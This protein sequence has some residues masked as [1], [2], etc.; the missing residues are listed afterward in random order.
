MKTHDQKTGYGKS[1][2]E[3]IP[4]PT[5]P[6]ADIPAHLTKD[7]VVAIVPDD[8]HTVGFQRQEARENSPLDSLP[9]NISAADSLDA[10]RKFW[11]PSWS[12]SAGEDSDQSKGRG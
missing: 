8:E 7:P 10:N 9:D 5:G 3:P 12:A 11:E 6:P 2:E 1:G 4:R